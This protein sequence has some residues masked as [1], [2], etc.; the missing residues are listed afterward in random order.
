MTES[1]AVDQGQRSFPFA[2]YSGSGSVDINR[3]A[4]DTQA[5]ADIIHYYAQMFTMQHDNTPPTVHTI[6]T[7]FQKICYSNKDA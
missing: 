4:A 3:S 7:L 2:L 1:T 6:A 5:V